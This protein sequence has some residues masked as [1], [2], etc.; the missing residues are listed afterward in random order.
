MKNFIE[1]MT[2]TLNKFDWGKSALDS[3]A[4]QFLNEWKT[5]FHVNRITHS[6]EYLKEKVKEVD[7][8]IL[9]KNYHSS[10]GGNMEYLSAWKKELLSKIKES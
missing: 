7:E 6:E 2:H 10:V 8:K 1:E 9:R 3:R 5:I 4:L